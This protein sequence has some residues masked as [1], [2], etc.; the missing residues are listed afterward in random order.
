MFS[1]KYFARGLADTQTISKTNKMCEN[2]DVF[3]VSAGLG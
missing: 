2:F 1:T 3:K